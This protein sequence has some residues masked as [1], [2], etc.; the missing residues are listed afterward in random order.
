MLVFLAGFELFIH[1]LLTV[2]C[3]N[4]R[5]WRNQSWKLAFHSAPATL[6]TFSSIHRSCMPTDV[7]TSSWLFY[8]AHIPRTPPI[9]FCPLTLDCPVI[10]Y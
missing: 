9:A 1:V 3:Y 2:A 7:Q 6:Q 5:L 4:H 8:G 10:K